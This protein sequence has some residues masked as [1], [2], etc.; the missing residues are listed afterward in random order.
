MTEQFRL[1]A[2][3]DLGATFLFALAALRFLSYT[4][5]Y[6]GSNILLAVCG[7]IIAALVT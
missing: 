3:S 4:V 1:P 2:A 6:A 5:R 7:S